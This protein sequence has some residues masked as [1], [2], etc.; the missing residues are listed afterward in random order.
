M[1]LVLIQEIL[2]DKNSNINEFNYKFNIM[3]NDKQIGESLL[4]QWFGNDPI[5]YLW[6]LTK[7]KNDI[8][9]EKLEEIECYFKDKYNNVYK[10]EKWNIKKP[11]QTTGY[12][13]LN[14][15]N[16]EEKTSFTTVIESSDSLVKTTGDNFVYYEFAYKKENGSLDYCFSLNFDN[17]KFDY[18][19]FKL[20]DYTYWRVDS[21]GDCSQWIK[22]PK[23]QKEIKQNFKI[24]EEDLNNF[25][26]ELEEVKTIPQAKD[27]VDNFL[28]VVTLFTDKR[29]GKRVLFETVLGINKPLNIEHE[30]LEQ[31]RNER[32]EKEELL[33]EECVVEQ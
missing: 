5:D 27:A 11:N 6:F 20:N 31:Y 1:K 3:L 12:L 4:P 28:K 2:D 30:K 9:I 33:N 10:E 23:T 26:F 7:L 13:Y 8:S 29:D 19:E 32:K 21:H 22:N 14:E 24:S 25:I 16:R 17:E 18:V 15:K